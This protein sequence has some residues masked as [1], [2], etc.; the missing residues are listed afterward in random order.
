MATT[1]K[2]ETANKKAETAQEFKE[3]YHKKRL[4]ALEAS[5][6]CL[7]NYIY[8][9]YLRNEHKDNAYLNKNL[10]DERVFEPEIIHFIQR[11]R[12]GL[13]HY[14]LYSSIC[15]WI[16]GAMESA[17]MIRNSLNEHMRY[18]KDTILFLLAGEALKTEL[19]DQ[20]LTDDI[21]R[22]FTP[23]TLDSVR[24]TETGY[25]KI[26]G[27]RFSIRS[28]IEN[29]LRYLNAYNTLIEII[30]EAVKIPE[31]SIFQVT[32]NSIEENM[33]VLNAKLETIR[34]EIIKRGGDETEAML[35]AFEPIDKKAPPI[36]DQNR[37]ETKA[38]I[39]RYVKH[40][41]ITFS[42]NTLFKTLCDNY[43]RR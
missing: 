39:S 22:L 7:L 15:N 31:L 23:L 36:P 34:E 32:M 13:G 42:G 2:A 16:G 17:V 25:Q 43:W 37:K 9:G 20:A 8:W 38:L 40:G 24:P 11:S 4:S 26:I 12:L 28:Y 1:K 29:Y 35:K 19:G 27:D 41:T 30:G 6:L 5:R 10:F 21:S 14:S 18:Y 3:K 33:D